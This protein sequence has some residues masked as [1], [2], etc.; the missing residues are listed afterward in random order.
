MGV[1][2]RM[3]S[4]IIVLNEHTSMTVIDISTAKKIGDRVG[5]P[6]LRVID[7][8]T[9]NFESHIQW[10]PSH[11]GILDN[12]IVNSLTKAASLETS[13]ND[14]PSTFSEM[15]SDSKKIRSQRDLWRVPPEHF[16]TGKHPRGALLFEGHSQ[17]TPI[18]RFASGHLQSLL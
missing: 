14:M 17:Q 18:S 12:K 7:K 8:L 6:I 3:R 2:P 16:S 13:R 1:T 11:V 4:K 5:I 10:I 9:A 15:F